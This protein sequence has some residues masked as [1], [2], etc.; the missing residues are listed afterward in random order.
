MSCYVKIIL[1]NYTRTIPY[2]YILGHRF[3]NKYRIQF[4]A[5]LKLFKQMYAIL[6]NKT[7]LMLGI[8]LIFFKKYICSPKGNYNTISM[9]LQ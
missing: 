9:S 7:K 2:N 4:K 8:F 3:Y 6:Y 1:Y 5:K